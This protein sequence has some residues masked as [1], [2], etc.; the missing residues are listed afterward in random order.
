MRWTKRPLLFAMKRVSNKPSQNMNVTF[1]L[2][3]V[4]KME[5]R[6]IDH[7]KITQSRLQLVHE[8]SLHM[9]NK[10]IGTSFEKC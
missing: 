3:D 6:T 10:S 1:E 8:P 2:L 5:I 4:P 7:S 9:E